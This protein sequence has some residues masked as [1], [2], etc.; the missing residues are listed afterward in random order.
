MP[1][2][3]PYYYINT[4]VVC[5]DFNAKLGL[6]EGEETFMGEEKEQETQTENDLPHLW[7]KRICMQQTRLSDIE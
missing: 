6:R 3:Y 1:P 2:F 5:G 4:V 7:T